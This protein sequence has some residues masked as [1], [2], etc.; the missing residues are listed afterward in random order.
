MR[1]YVPKTG[2]RNGHHKLTDLPANYQPGFVARLAHR[3]EI[4][5]LRR[6]R[7]EGI[8]TDLG[9]ADEL[10]GIK[11]SL[12]ERFVFLEASLSRMESEIATAPDLKTLSDVSARW[13]QGC[14]A[15]LGLAKTLGI[16]RQAANRPWVVSPGSE[17]C[18]AVDRCKGQRGRQGPHTPAPGERGGLVRR[19]VGCCGGERRVRAGGF[20]VSSTS[21][22]SCRILR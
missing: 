14:K 17:R 2:R 19:T 7:Y 8:A 3:T 13:T 22:S 10:S 5:R 9:G 12:L 15:L 16:E 20:Y 6:D 11:A 21:I 18:R 4:A 1:T